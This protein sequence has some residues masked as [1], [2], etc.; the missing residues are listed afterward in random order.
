MNAIRT[1]KFWIACVLTVIATTGLSLRTHADTI[2]CQN[3]TMM[4][5]DENGNTEPTGFDVLFTET[6]VTTC[7]GNRVR[8]VYIVDGGSDT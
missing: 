5:T 1:S 3:G 8:T 4:V 6:S 7:E 2:S